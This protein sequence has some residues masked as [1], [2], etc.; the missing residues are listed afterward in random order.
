MEGSLSV[1]PT[2]TDPPPKDSAAASLL[3]QLCRFGASEL[4]WCSALALRAS[5]LCGGRHCRIELAAARSTRVDPQYYW[6]PIPGPRTSS[7]KAEAW[8]AVERRENEPAGAVPEEL[9]GLV[10]LAG[11]LLERH[12]LMS[13]VGRARRAAEET[14]STLGHAVRN[15]LNPA[16]LRAEYL[17]M[18]M[19]YGGPD[20]AEVKKSLDVFVRSVQELV[21]QIHQLL[22]ASD[23]HEQSP[24]RTPS[25]REE[26]VRVPDLLRDTAEA[27][28]TAGGPLHVEVV[29]EVPPV[30]A[31]RRRLKPIL[32]EL[33]D[34][35][36]ESPGTP[37]LTVR[38]E[39]ASSGVRVVLSVDLQPVSAAPSD[40]R[41]SARRQEAAAG[42][43]EASAGSARFDRDASGP[44]RPS[45]R[46]LLGELGARLSI[47][48][49]AGTRLVMILMLPVGASGECAGLSPGG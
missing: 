34:L 13:E 1:V 49:Y 16:F 30:R 48:A 43:S 17:L 46:E 18:Q 5:E 14:R 4:A 20:R 9:G 10:D 26:P 22:E 32:E 28:G 27:P 7:G 15:Q 39:V 42:R 23:G 29:G 33:I 19:R 8:L 2:G 21:K 6:V 41:G 11:L 12:R 31:D 45:L 44:P 36:R 3:E 35:V 25:R 37:T 40:H 47:D 38:P 24:V